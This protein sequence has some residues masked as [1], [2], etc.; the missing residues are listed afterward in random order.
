MVRPTRRLLVAHLDVA[1]IDTLD[2]DERGLDRLDLRDALLAAFPSR[3]ALLE[4]LDVAGRGL[5]RDIAEASGPRDAIFKVVQAALA[6]GK[7]ARLLVEAVNM[8]NH[9]R[10]V[11]FVRPYRR[12][13]AARASAAAPDAAEGAPAGI[14]RTPAEVHVQPRRWLLASTENFDLTEPARV[15]RAAKAE[16]AGTSRPIGLATSFTDPSYLEVLVERIRHVFLNTEPRT[17]TTLASHLRG[18]EQ[19][20]ATIAKHR[21][22]LNSTNIVCVVNVGPPERH[23][24]IPEPLST[25]WRRIHGTCDGA[26]HRLILL[27]AIYPG[28]GLPPAVR[29]HPDPAVTEHDVW[30]W[31]SGVMKEAARS[32]GLDENLREA[33][34]RRLC[35]EAF[36]PMSPDRLDLCQLYLV[37]KEDIRLLGND[38]PGFTRML[39]GITSA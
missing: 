6:E 37:M 28:V 35:A 27:F 25:F 29:E 32:H 39:E 24:E 17:G 26:T 23:G 2:D 12:D 34:H 36:D 11:E 14:A 1:R 20:V 18:P 3:G 4:L 19:C 33:W 10:L 38:L 15:I 9:P 13:V 22:S 30:N 21:P 5:G 16:S 7:L 8:S 31:T